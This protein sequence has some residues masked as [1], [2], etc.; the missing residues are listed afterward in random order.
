MRSLTPGISGARVFRA[1]PFRND[2]GETDCVLKIDKASVLVRE[3]QKYEEVVQGHIKDRGARV[4]YQHDIA[5]IARQAGNTFVAI[6]YEHAGSVRFGEYMAD[7][8]TAA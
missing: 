2:V 8:G 7:A 3:A 6:Q 1:K 5:E 4:T